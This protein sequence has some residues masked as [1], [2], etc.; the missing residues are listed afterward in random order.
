[1]PIDQ[2]LDVFLC[3]CRL[4]H[5]MRYFGCFLSFFTADIVRQQGN[6]PIKGAEAKGLLMGGGAPNLKI[7]QGNLLPLNA[8]LQDRWLTERMNCRLLLCCC[9]C[10]L[11]AHKTQ[12]P[13][14][15]TSFPSGDRTQE[16]DFGRDVSVEKGSQSHTDGSQAY[17]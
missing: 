17:G 13:L 6:G 8:P 11:L 4:S 3:V 1:M 10:H 14:L 5:L 16:R 9:F 7:R 2:E 12:H 15:L